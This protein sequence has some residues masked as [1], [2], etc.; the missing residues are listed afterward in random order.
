MA[1]TEKSNF[2]S[3]NVLKKNGF[4]F[5]KEYEEE[6][7][8]DAKG[9]KKKHLVDMWKLWKPGFDGDKGA[10]EMESQKTLYHPY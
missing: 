10:P 2:A 3:A 4:Q 8:I 6:M 5:W 1:I 9:T 7:E